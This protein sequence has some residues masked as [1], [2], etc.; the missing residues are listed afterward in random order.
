MLKEHDCSFYY[1]VSFYSWTSILFS[2][3]KMPKGDRVR[4]TEATST[5]LLS[6]KALDGITNL[7]DVCTCNV[8]HKD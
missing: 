7:L 6:L 4:L 2:Q 5:C 8:R 3:A 1:F